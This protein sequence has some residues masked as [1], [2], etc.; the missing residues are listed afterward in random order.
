LQRVV[1]PEDLV[2]ATA[3][4]GRGRREIQFFEAFHVLSPLSS[5]RLAHPGKDCQLGGISN[6]LLD[7][8][9]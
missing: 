5:V 9:G 1:D 4:Q 2:N 3:E 7:P 8:L 6:L